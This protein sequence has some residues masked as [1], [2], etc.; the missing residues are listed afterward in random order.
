MAFVCLTV[1]VASC[2]WQSDALKVGEDTY[3][4][5]AN[6]SPARGGETGARQ[7]ALTDANQKCDAL[8]KKIEV[9]NVEI[10]HAF[11]ANGVATVTFTCK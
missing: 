9:T 8:G 10:T 6:A 4:V 7:M 1:A 5:S 2:A 11:P 3:Q